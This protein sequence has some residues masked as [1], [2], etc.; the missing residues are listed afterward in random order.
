MEEI[1]DWEKWIE[2]KINEWEQDNLTNKDLW[3]QFQDDFDE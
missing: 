2:T 1:Q 3:E